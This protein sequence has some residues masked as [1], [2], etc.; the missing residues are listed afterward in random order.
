MIDLGF[1]SWLAS[2]FAPAPVP[3]SGDDLAAFTDEYMELY[4][5]IY[6]RELAFWSATNL[7]ANS[8]SKC[9]FKTFKKR[10]EVKGTRIFL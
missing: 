2:K 4:G 3:L 7:I 8:V 6:I 10:E 5:D 1:I 9:E